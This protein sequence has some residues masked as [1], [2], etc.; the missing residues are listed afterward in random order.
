MRRYLGLFMLILALVLLAACQGTNGVGGETSTPGS[1]DEVVPQGSPTSAS[2]PSEA[3]TTPIPVDG[4]P[5]PPPTSVPSPE[6]YPGPPTPIPTLDPYPAGVLIWIVRPVGEQCADPEASE[7]SDLQ[8]AV[9]ELAAA[10]VP[11][12]SS[13]TVD[14]LVCAACGCPTSTH[15]R[16][17][18]QATNFSRAES[19]GWVRGE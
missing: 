14:L 18:I 11:V 6:G 16:V 2:V 8:E 12:E 17:Q 9:A 13:G 7:V 19:L 10:G 3:T 1:G 5:P 4:Y 15:Y